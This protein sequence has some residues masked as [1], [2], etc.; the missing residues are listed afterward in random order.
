MYAY[1]D[2]MWRFGHLG[3][4]ARRYLGSIRVWLGVGKEG[5]HF[6]KCNFYLR[7]SSDLPEI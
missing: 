6:S 2:L 7:P 3:I 1:H 4:W 5:R